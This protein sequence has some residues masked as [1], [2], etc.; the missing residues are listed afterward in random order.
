MEE[1]AWVREL[2]AA[3]TVCD[4]EGVTL[5]MN[6][7]AAQTH[8]KDG[9]R[10]LIGRSLVECHPE[11]ARSHLLELLRTGQPNVYTIEKAGVKKLIYQ[12]PW[13]QG[14]EYKGFVELSLPIPFELPHFV[15]E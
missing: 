2:K 15:R 10:E 6:D 9:G 14:G 7:R 3:I 5:E 13:F 4:R 11:P 8:E 12:A 1:G